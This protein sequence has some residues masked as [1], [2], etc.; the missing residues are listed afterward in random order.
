MGLCGIRQQIVGFFALG[1]SWLLVPPWHVEATTGGGEAR[2]CSMLPEDRKWISEALQQ[3]WQVAQRTIL[4]A[5]PKPLPSIIAFDARCSYRLQP[6]ASQEWYGH[7]HSGQVRLPNGATTEVGPTA[8]HAATKSGTFLVFSLPSIWRAHAP[9]GPIPLDWFL[10]GILFHELT[11][12]YQAVVSPSFASDLIKAELSFA[13]ASD[14]GVEKMFK[15]DVLYRRAYETERDTLFRAAVAA[16]DD[17]ARRLA[18]EAGTLIRKRRAIYFQGEAARWA[19]LDEWSLTTEG[20]ASW[21]SYAWLTRHRR[22]A[23]ALAVSKLRGSSWSQDE[24][25]AIFLVVDRLLP[26]WQG[27]LLATSPKPATTLLDMACKS[28]VTSPSRR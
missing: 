18:C 3:N 6:D 1:L 4:L 16:N 28:R 5:E 13:D 21:I 7:I 2:S 19:G 17:E 23:P 11:H 9:P 26:S 22:V 15:S 25:L 12:H 14:D 20:V 24:G 10:E 8:F 27:E